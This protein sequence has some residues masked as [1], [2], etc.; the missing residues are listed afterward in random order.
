MKDFTR[1][2]IGS[3]VIL[4]GI[5]LLLDQTGLSDEFRLDWLFTNLWPVFLIL[6]GISFLL[7]KDIIPG[8]IITFLGISF[9]SSSLFD[10]SIWGLIWPMFIIGGGIIILFRGSLFNIAKIK[11]SG[12]K[13]DANAVFWGA[14]KKVS[15]ENY[16]GGN[17]DC[18]CGGVEYDLSKVQISD[19]GALLNITVVCGGV[20]IRVPENIEVINNI[21]AVFAGVDDKT[22]VSGKPIGTITLSG[23][24]FLGG[25]EVKN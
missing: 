5:G 22:Y 2:L 17:I 18:I 12:R 13:V 19:K 15:S 20:E 4:F 7:K 21:S 11:S 24:A 14:E 16:E 3:F 8:T 23:S 9:L 1:V 10:W 25:I 6:L